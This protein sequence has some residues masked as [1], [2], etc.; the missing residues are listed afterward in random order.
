MLREN[1]CQLRIPYTVKLSVRSE[2]K[3]KRYTIYY[4]MKK[5]IWYL[6]INLTKDVKNFYEENLKALLK[7]IKD[8]LK[9]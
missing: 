5:T 8:N 6:E 4:T 2:D 3:I 7:D 1:S 9:K